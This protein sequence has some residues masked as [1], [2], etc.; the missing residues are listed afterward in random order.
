M[1]ALTSPIAHGE[2]EAA[3]PNGMIAYTENAVNSEMNGA[4][5]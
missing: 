1:P 4:K 2:P 3:A 5:R